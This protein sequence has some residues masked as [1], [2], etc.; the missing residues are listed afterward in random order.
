MANALDDAEPEARE[1]LI[2]GV[3]IRTIDAT[4]YLAEA[5]EAVAAAALIAAQCPE[6][7][8]VDTPY[9]PETP[10]PVFPTD[11]RALADESK[12]CQNT[13][14]VAGAPVGA[15]SAHPA[16]SA[17]RRSSLRSPTEPSKCKVAAAPSAAGR[18]R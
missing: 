17:G 1:A 8:P 16:G 12:V 13:S 6:G 15:A 2:R 10:M 5:E 7:E 4:G 11:L 3:L 9:G 18:I 14:K